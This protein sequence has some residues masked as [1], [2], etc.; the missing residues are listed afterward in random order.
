MRCEYLAR[1]TPAQSEPS[2]AADDQARL[3]RAHDARSASG[4][5]ARMRRRTSQGSTSENRSSGPS[6]ALS[7]TT[8]ASIDDDV[9]GR[10]RSQLRSLLRALSVRRRV[11]PGGARTVSA[12]AARAAKRPAKDRGHGTLRCA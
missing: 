1:S 2:R 12:V 8:A 10:A 3:T 11:L 4:S 6:A 5:S 7:V 9:V